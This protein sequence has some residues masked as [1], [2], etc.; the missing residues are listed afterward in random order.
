MEERFELQAEK[1]FL[2]E[3]KGEGWFTEAV[4][5]NTKQTA[6]EQADAIAG[7]HEDYMLVVVDEAC[8]IADNVFKKLERTLTSKL[9]LMLLI[10]NPTKTSGYAIE[11]QNDARF[12]ALRWNAEDSELVTREQIE[13]MEEKYGRDSNPF[14][15]S[16]LG[17]PPITETDAFL[18]LDWIE[19]AVNAS[20]RPPDNE[21]VITSLD[22]G[23]GGDKSI[24]LKRQGGY[25]FPLQRRS[26][27]E[28]SDLIGWAWNNSSE[29]DVLIVDKK[30]PGWAVFGR[31]HELRGKDKVTKPYDGSMTSSNKNRWHNVRDE[32]H[33]ILRDRFESRTISIPDDKD[34]IFMLMALKGKYDSNGAIHIIEKAKVKK[35]LGKSSDETDALAMNLYIKDKNFRY[36][37]AGVKPE[38]KKT[39]TYYEK[40]AQGDAAWMNL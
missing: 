1:L 30:G 6:E 38:K 15:I 36:L 40:T 5:I 7:R 18:P 3:V 19:E 20:D 8:G 32:A 27:P 39:T 12:I 11:S 21:P 26:T 34:L 16:V 2:K 29:S 22:C 14:R 4:T 33:S 13:A 31:L 35:I 17:L 9:N 24:L 10:F 37:V 25:V 23:A 28:S